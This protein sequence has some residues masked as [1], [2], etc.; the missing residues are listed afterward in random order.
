[1]LLYLFLEADGHALYLIVCDCSL[2]LVLLV[3]VQVNAARGC[4]ELHV[5]PASQL[6]HEQYLVRHDHQF[7]AFAASSGILDALLEVLV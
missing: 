3:R 5:V 7:V 6:V 1:M 2:D 4:H